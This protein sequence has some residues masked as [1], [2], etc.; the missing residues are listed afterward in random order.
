MEQA[1]VS[2]YRDRKKQSG[3]TIR[4]TQY[5][6]YSSKLN[7]SKNKKH[8]ISQEGQVYSERFPVQIAHCSCV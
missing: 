6:S 5:F 2:Q 7:T 1:E 8:R 4:H 3:K